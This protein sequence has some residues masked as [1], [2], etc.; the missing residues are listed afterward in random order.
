MQEEKIRLGGIPRDL[1]DQLIPKLAPYQV[2]LF[3]VRAPESQAPFSYIGSGVLVTR[4]D[5]PYLLT[6]GHVWDQLAYFKE[7]GL[8]ISQTLHDTRIH[9]DEVVPF[10]AYDRANVEWGPDIAFLR[11]SDKAV[12]TIGAEKKYHPVDPGRAGRDI[13]EPDETAGIIAVIGAPAESSS[14]GLQTA[15][16]HAGPWV[17]GIERYEIRDGFDYFDLGVDVGSPDMP[18]SFGGISGGPAWQ[19]VLYRS[20]SGEHLVWKAP[21]QLIGIV[22]SESKP[23]G[24]RRIVRCHGPRAIYVE[25]PRLAGIIGQSHRST[26]RRRRP[27]RTT[28]APRNPPRQS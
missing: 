18:S 11:L 20:R 16:L 10:M 8:G 5:V 9:R 23:E 17:G 13:P 15:A 4:G 28:G 26:S 7:I 27:R 19:V 25:G 24:G 21:P 14:I 22:L 6:A 12:D 2:A 3:G 1:F